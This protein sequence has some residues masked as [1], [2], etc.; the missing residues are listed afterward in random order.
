MQ[1]QHLFSPLL[2]HVKIVII[3]VMCKIGDR[4]RKGTPKR[5]TG[6]IRLY[7][8]TQVSHS[9]PPIVDTGIRRK[10]PVMRPWL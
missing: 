10:G 6:A 8:E 1:G 9:D 3:V 5:E 2:N 7:C 4:H